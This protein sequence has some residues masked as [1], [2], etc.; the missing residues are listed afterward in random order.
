MSWNPHGFGFF[1][2]TGGSLPA[3]LPVN[4]AKC[5]SSV[6][7]SPNEYAV[8][9]PARQTYSHSA[10]DGSR[11][12]SP[13]PSSLRRRSSSVTL[14]QNVRASSQLTNS[15][16]LRGPFH[17]DGLPPATRKY[18]SCVTSYFAIANGFLNVTLW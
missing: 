12:A 9:V 18:S 2:P 15:T 5:V 1:L 7:A 8:V 13:T 3:A 14:R 4:Q 6:A 10:S 11:I 16:E 17:F